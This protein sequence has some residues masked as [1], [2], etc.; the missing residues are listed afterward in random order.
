MLRHEIAQTLVNERYRHRALNI[1]MID[2]AMITRRLSPII[3][4]VLTLF[5][6]VGIA[7]TRADTNTYPA[8][9]EGKP[10]TTISGVQ[11]WD[12]VVGTGATAVLGKTVGVH[13]RWLTDGRKFDSSVDRGNPVAF[14][15][16][17]GRD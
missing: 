8:R 5:A 2:S 9:V 14:P 6:A 7:P 4:L 17:A 10:K 15:L 11:Y 13:R 12:I 16:G 3:V 1:E